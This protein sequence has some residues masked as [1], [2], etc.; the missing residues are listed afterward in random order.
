[1]TPTVGRTAITGTPRRLGKGRTQCISVF[2]RREINSTSSFITG[3]SYMR[4][5]LIPL[6]S[7]NHPAGRTGRQTGGALLLLILLM[8]AL[9]LAAPERSHAAGGD[10]MANFPA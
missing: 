4:Q 3:G 9:F 5:S 1:M 8:T 10:F 2:W 6:T 7:D